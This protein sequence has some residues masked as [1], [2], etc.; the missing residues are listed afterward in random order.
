[1][2][3]STQTVDPKNV[4]KLDKNDIW[5]LNGAQT[6]LKQ[7]Q[8][9]F[10]QPYLQLLRC[11]SYSLHKLDDIGKVLESVKWEQFHAD[12]SE[13]PLFLEL[14]YQIRT[15][16]SRKSQLVPELDTFSSE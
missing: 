9:L 1:M 15:I 10:L 12:N 6:M 14:L 5:M 2:E 7:N 3:P 8:D 4:S 11:L 13:S 16:L